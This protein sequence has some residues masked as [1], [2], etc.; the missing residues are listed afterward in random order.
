MS[1]AEVASLS[2]REL[3]G[4]HLA[5]DPQAFGELFRRHRDRMYAVA[6]RTLADPEL[7]ADAVQ[8]AFISAFRRADSYR[9][10]A[11]VTTWLHRIVVN[12]CLDRVRRER[13]VLRHAGDLAEVERPDPTDAHHRTEVRLIVQEA[14]AALP[15][16]QRL[17]VVLVDMEGLPIAEVAEILE[18]AEG[19]VKSRCS[20]GNRSP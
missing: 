5:G 15:L 3:L 13:T 20:R 8:D 11:A 19:T 7:A 16:G 9:G 2:D 14:L 17:A 10:D 6:M 18:I 1:G 12:A 4:A